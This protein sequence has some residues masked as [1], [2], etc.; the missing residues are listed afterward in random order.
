MH[1]H[2]SMNAAFTPAKK[3]HSDLSSWVFV[4]LLNSLLSVP[5]ATDL[6]SNRYSPY[7]PVTNMTEGIAWPKGQAL[8]TFANTPSPHDRDKV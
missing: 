4:A 3:F 5:A 6:D 2:C 7:P 1:D 8:P